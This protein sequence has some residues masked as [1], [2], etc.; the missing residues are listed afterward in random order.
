M[1]R[2]L[3]QGGNIKHE[4]LDPIKW[5]FLLMEAQFQFTLLIMNQYTSRE[6]LLKMNLDLYIPIKGSLITRITPLY[7]LGQH[8]DIILLFILIIYPLIFYSFIPQLTRV[9]PLLHLFP[10]PH[11]LR[12]RSHLDL[13]HHILEW[14]SLCL[15][16]AAVHPFTPPLQLSTP[17]RFLHL[18]QR[19]AQLIHT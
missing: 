7:E 3:L 11:N 9:V 12:F 17:L 16:S 1:Y 10:F 14:P 5:L 18:N 6:G 4:L 2:I 15:V 13:R 8:P 19:L